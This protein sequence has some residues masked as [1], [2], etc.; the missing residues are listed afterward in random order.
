MRVQ[1]KIEMERQRGR[2][3]KGKKKKKTK[4]IIFLTKL[5]LY[6]ADKIYPVITSYGRWSGERGREELG[7]LNECASCI[8]NFPSISM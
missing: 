1:I 5:C 8:H 3:A 4:N 2:G 6:L 7:I